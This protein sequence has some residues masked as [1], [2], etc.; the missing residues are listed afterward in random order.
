MMAD[1]LRFLVEHGTTIMVS[2]VVFCL[3]SLATAIMTRGDAKPSTNKKTG[4]RSLER[5]RNGR[6]WKQRINLPNN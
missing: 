5:K 3:C 4:V 6:S 2:T 1:T